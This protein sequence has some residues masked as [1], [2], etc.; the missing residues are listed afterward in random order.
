MTDK[1]DSVTLT[2]VI[3]QCLENSMDGRFTQA[4]RSEFLT[5]A[6]RLRGSLLNLLS[7][8]F[9]EGTAV[10]KETNGTL[11]NVNAELKNA[12]ASLAKA[13]QTLKDL[14]ALVGSL[15]KLI[16]VAGMFL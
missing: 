9:D 3:D 1:V 2:A 13:A 11:A 6:K 10:L 7:A 8:R 14:N 15:D 16:G 4:Q 12:A 5:L